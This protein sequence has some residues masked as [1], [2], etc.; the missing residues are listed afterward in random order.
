MTWGILIAIVFLVLFIFA[1]L[2]LGE[3]L[4]KVTASQAGEDASDY[5]V[6]PSS[7]RSIMGR[8]SG[9]PDYVP[10]GEHVKQLNRGFDINLLG[11]AE[12][13][14]G[15]PIRKLRSTTYAL[16][17]KDFIGMSP[18]PKVIPEVGTQ[19][20]A[21]DP[22]FF[23][24]KRPEIIYAAPVSGEYIELRRG[25]KRSVDEIVILA[26]QGEVQYR[27]YENIP[28]LS[29]VAREDLVSFLTASGAWPF[30]RQRPFD[31]VAD[32]TET[33]KSIFVSTFDTAPLAPNLNLAVEG[34]EEVFQKGLEVLTKLTDGKVHLGLDARGTEAPAKAFTEANIEGVEK[35]WFS[36]QHPAGNV[37]IH[38]HHVDPVLP[39]GPAVWHLTVHGVLVLGS[40]FLNGKFDTETLI[41]VTGAEL[42]EPYYAFAHQGIALETLLEDMPN[43]FEEHT[44]LVDG[45]EG[46]VEEVQ[47]RRVIRVVSGDLLSG[48]QVERNSFLSFFDDQISTVKEGDYYEIFGW[49]IPQ[50][51]HPT[52]S[53]TFPNGF[54]SSSTYRADT[55]TN[56]EKRAFV[57]SG[58][59]EEVLPMDIYP[60]HVMR[61]VMAKDYEKM[62]GLGILELGEEDIAICEYVCTSKQPLQSML[63]EGLDELRE[64]M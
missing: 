62:E 25:E 59:Y 43:D 34:K 57:V 37:G 49:L 56:G 45:D 63:R 61:A 41:A 48:K 55:N 53:R 51:G 24:K 2:T 58:Q 14:I 7:L 19:V 17:P 31:V 47:K 5:S 9:K 4:L 29:S 11:E 35:H 60:Q 30:I 36:G 13:K 22:L 1:L 40:I 16:K 46:K 38:I 10:E 52:I 50:K 6:L 54:V 27:E 28:D 64:Q 3:G 20:K 39:G 8:S 21:G 23:D 15:E 32:P 26:D 33:P 44:V 42:D 18:I 12:A